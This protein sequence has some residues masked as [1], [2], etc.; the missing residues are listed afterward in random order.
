MTF[1]LRQALAA[2]SDKR[3]LFASICDP[4]TCDLLDGLDL[5]TKTEIELGVGHDAMSEKVKLEVTV[6]SKGQVVRADRDRNRRHRQ[7]IWQVRRRPCGRHG[8]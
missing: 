1:I 8:D 3:I 5:G 2:K 7:D 6:L 4:K